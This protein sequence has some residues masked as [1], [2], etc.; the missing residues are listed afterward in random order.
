MRYRTNVSAARLDAASAPIDGGEGSDTLYG[1]ADR[2]LM[3]GFG[4]DDYMNGG[5]GP[6]RMSGGD[7][8]DY[9][10]GYKG[11]DRLWG[12]EGND[13]LK[14]S[15]GDDVLSGGGG[16]DRLDG[17]EEFRQH[18]R[19][20]DDLLMGGEGAD[21]LTSLTGR[22]TLAGGAGDDLLIRYD[23]DATLLG[24]D[25]EDVIDANLAMS[26]GVVVDGGNQ[27]AG[28]ADYFKVLTASSEGPL[29]FDLRAC[30]AGEVQ[31]LAGGATVVGIERVS[32]NIG[33]G[34][35]NL[36]IGYDFQ[37][38]VGGGTGDDTL[39]GGGGDDVLHGGR[40]GLSLIHGED[41]NDFLLTNCPGE[42]YGGEGDD[43]L[44][45]TR[46]DP[47]M[48][49]SLDGGAGN[50]TLSGGA[51]V[52][53]MRGGAGADVFRYESRKDSAPS[54]TGQTTDLI[55]DL[56]DDDLIHLLKVDADSQTAG[57]QAFVLVEAFSGAAGEL[58]LRY[59]A[60]TDMT[61]IEG[62]TDDHA[63]IDFMIRV[64]GDHA[65]FEGFVL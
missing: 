47:S 16:A 17:D 59:D 58:R 62:Q 3:R 54:A 35:D 49:V 5:L 27:G 60:G 63:G 61:F 43:R 44:L 4:G 28:E 34:A 24:G 33:N 55:L 36:F 45:A 1:T 53:R 42:L 52:D 26:A 15:A 2:D 19:G 22:D 50:D 51:G 7:G 18:V 32:F 64:R 41:G 31:T 30:A 38:V 65:D 46:T 8:R 10:D 11:A 13:T 57:N 20:G 56:G 37:D 12:D 40:G 21:S 14:G 29:A 23:G 6:D 39:Y 48:N 25:G 9:L